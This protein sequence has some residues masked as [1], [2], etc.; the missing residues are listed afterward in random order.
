MTFRGPRVHTGQRFAFRAGT[1]RLAN[2][3]RP[4]GNRLH[5]PHPKPNGSAP[6]RTRLHAACSSPPTP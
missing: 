5:G 6:I 2:R 3:R 1:R 4:Q